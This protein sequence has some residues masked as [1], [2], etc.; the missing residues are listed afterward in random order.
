[1]NELVPGE[2]D[3]KATIEASG[4]GAGG[5]WIPGKKSLAPIVWRIKWP[6][7]VRR[8]ISTLA[9]PTGVITSP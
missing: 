4:K 3:Y 8:R 7:E 9:K 5:V 1:M 6:E 2:V